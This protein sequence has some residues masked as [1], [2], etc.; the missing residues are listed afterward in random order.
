MRNFSKAI[1]FAVG[2]AFSL[3]ASAADS[4]LSLR[5][6]QSP[7]ELSIFYQ[8]QKLL[9]YMLEAHP[10]KPYIKELYNSKGAAVLRDSP[11]DHLHH[12]GL[13]YAI[14]VNGINFWEEIAASGFEKPVK[15][16]RHE[17]G[18]NREGL[19]R[20]TFAQLIHWIRPE[21]KSL[22]DTTP[23]ALLVEQRTITL[24]IDEAGQEVAVE[25]NSTFEVGP[26]TAR[27]V[28]TGANYHGLGLRFPQ[29]LDALAKHSN[30]EKAP[31]LANGKQDVSPAK[32]SSVYFP[33]P[34]Q[35]LTVS[36]FG[37]AKNVRGEARFFTMLTPFA[38]LSATQGLDQQSLT[39]EQGDKFALTY[40]I[41]VYPGAKSPE[42]LRQ[43]NQRWQS[44][45]GQP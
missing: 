1:W 34:D 10:Y 17:I 22:V 36:L 7:D 27:V 19:P 31:D 20:A 29:A 45:I 33:A 38:Y 26:K 12:H 9:V 13:M 6:S 30:S 24:T 14:K 39:Y 4:P 18:Q 41:T 43:R 23:A 21:D 32:W 40:L 11:A 3:S 5:F 44:S 37:G 35:P 8:Q 42:F 2:L 15:L 28:L 25:W 16:L